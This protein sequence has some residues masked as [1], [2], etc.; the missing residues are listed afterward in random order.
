MIKSIALATFLS[1]SAGPL[2]AADAVDG[3]PEA[4]AAAPAATTFSWVGAYAGLHAGYGWADGTFSDGVTTDTLDFDG[5]RFGG[6]VGYNW[7]V[8]S[9]VIAGVE[10][11]LSYDANEETYAG[12]DGQTSPTG[13][14]R[15]R[16]G[17]AMDRALIYGAAGWTVTRFNA[18]GAGVDESETLNGW[19]VGAGVDY[20]FTDRIFGRV[21]YRYNDYSEKTVA[22]FIDT[23]SEQ[24]VV[25]VGVGVK[26]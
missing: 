18:D 26:F 12:D 21:E 10:A 9:N 8:A 17:Y 7:A 4:P 15:A 3:V 19:T 25:N 13:G 14:I 16:V 22:G 5:G 24:H 1:L 11:D 2:L 20:A 6:F 23:D